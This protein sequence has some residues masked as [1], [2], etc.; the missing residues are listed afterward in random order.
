MQ[1]K[2]HHHEPAGVNLRPGISAHAVVAGRGGSRRG[3]PGIGRG[4]GDTLSRLLVS[5]LRLC[6][7]VRTLAA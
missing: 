3:L 7:A 2:L 1:V 4:A 6:E 5:S